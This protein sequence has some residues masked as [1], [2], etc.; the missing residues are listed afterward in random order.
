MPVQT[1]YSFPS[2]APLVNIGVPAK[3]TQYST[4]LELLAHTS[5]HTQEIKH[6]KT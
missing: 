3:D 2:R 1:E 5:L 6:Y 4:H